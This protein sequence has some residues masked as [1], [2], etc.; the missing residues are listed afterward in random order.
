[1]PR[2]MDR[3]REIREKQN[4]SQRDLARLCGFGNLQIFRYEN[5]K[6]DPSAEHLTIMAEKLK[7]SADY[8][9]GLSDQPNGIGYGTDL[10]E[11][12]REILQVFRRKGW[13][14]VLRL[15]AEHLGD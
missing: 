14:G 12:E 7:V 2:P 5:G 13:R 9:I 10:N 4:M 15:V 11:L 3:L 1:M 8:L 6:S